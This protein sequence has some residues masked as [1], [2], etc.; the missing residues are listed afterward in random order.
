MHIAAH[1]KT[2]RKALGSNQFSW[3]GRDCV[4]VGVI[5]HDKQ[6]Q[7][8]NQKGTHLQLALCLPSS[9]KE[10]VAKSIKKSSSSVTAPRKGQKTKGKQERIAR[11][12]SG[13]AVNE[14]LQAR[15][16]K[17]TAQRDEA[18][19]KLN[20]TRSTFDSLFQANPIPTALTNIQDDSFINAN[21][22]FLKYFDLK[23]EEVIGHT[24]QDLNL[25]VVIQPPERTDLLEQLQKEGGIRNFER[26][27]TL[28]SGKNVTVLASLQYLHTEEME[29]ILSAFI[30][31]T[32]RKQAEAI[33]RDI[34]DAAPD[35]TVII[36]AD[37]KIVLV[38][39]QMEHV[40]GHA[41]EEL[42]GKP[43]STL[44]PER[45]HGAH[46][47]HRLEY[48]REPMARPMGSDLKLYGRRWD[49]TE[50][51]VE[52]SLSP[53]QT[54]DGMLAIAAIRDITRRTEAEQ[55]I[56][57]LS[58][59][60]SEAEQKERQRLSQVLHDDLQQRLFALKLQLPILESESSQG[61]REVIRALLAEMEEELTESIFIT[62]NLS[63][64]LSP[65]TLQG[66]NLV[67]ALTALS[68]RMQKQYGLTIAL[69]T[70]GIETNFDNPLSELIFQTVRELL[71]NVVK[72]AGTLEA[73]MT[74]ERVDNQ[75]RITVSDGGQGFDPAAVMSE[76][77]ASHGLLDIRQRLEPI[78][79]QMEIASRPGAGT[80]IVIHCPG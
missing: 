79:C 19:R 72:H 29:A 55:K 71:F 26:E 58:H 28:P 73:T 56:R 23:L 32:E 80:R 66:T 31:I 70:N 43:V 24:V 20:Q 16:V 53:L 40:F 22:A 61:N 77:G 60:L 68:T 18:N 4:P 63:I 62:R 78:G 36:D 75:L 46:P 50:F 59:L 49:G 39:K 30:D 6:T 21:V 13:L 37:G 74:L 45:F 52:I 51:P 67:N 25:G 3:Y 15:V 64:D 48:F 17:R 27:M 1:V 2:F 7:R 35:A 14:S 34:V 5:G 12:H 9:I 65:I 47:R 76:A 11:A 10:N 41:R 33:L 8:Y 69:Q 38:N 42:I 54:P 44:L 57:R